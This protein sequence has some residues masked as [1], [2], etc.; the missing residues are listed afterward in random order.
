MSTHLSDILESPES[1]QKWTL[2]PTGNLWKNITAI[3]AAIMISGCASQYQ[4]RPNVVVIENTPYN[5][6]NVP[7]YERERILD[8]A[9]RNT[10]TRISLQEEQQRLDAKKA[11]NARNTYEEQERLNRRKRQ[12][13][14]EQG[15]VV[16]PASGKPISIAP[17]GDNRHWNIRY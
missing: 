9:L 13:E 8:N 17:S 11:R 5:E 6:P 10:R 1:P 12:F 3:I 2:S 14:Q 7:L 16:P 4:T 15:R